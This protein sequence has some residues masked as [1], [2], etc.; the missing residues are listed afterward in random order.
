MRLGTRHI[1][2]TIPEQV[3]GVLMPDAQFR[4]GDTVYNV[5]VEC[6][7][8]AKA[9]EQVVRNVKKGREAGNRVLLVLPDQSGVSRALAILD[10]AFPGMRLWPDGVGLVWRGENG[11]FHPHR[12]PGTSIWPFLEDDWRAEDEPILPE[13]EGPIEPVQAA[14]DPLARLLRGIIQDFLKAGK[15]EAT[16]GENLR[17]P[18]ALGTG[19]PNG[20]AGR[21]RPERPRVEASPSPAQRESAHSLRPSLSE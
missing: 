7:T 11:M 2:I 10:Q 14:T 16:S 20:R 15:T 17:G 12:A 1:A 21:G 6:S 19:P 4:Y 18:A 13:G 5:E 9:A 8:V 3:A